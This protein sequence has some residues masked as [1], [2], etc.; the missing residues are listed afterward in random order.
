VAARGWPFLVDAAP[1]ALRQD[2]VVPVVLQF[3]LAAP[4]DRALVFT[5]KQEPRLIR[6]ATRQSPERA[7]PIE[8]CG[9]MPTLS[10]CFAHQP[11]AR[12]SGNAQG[13]IVLGPEPEHVDPLL[14]EDEAI[15]VIF[16][17]NRISDGHH[18]PKVHCP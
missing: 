12:G 3:L 2:R 9:I 8:T 14:I 16:V 17:G 18:A 5:A 6:P 7:V 11:H 13:R 10:K 1:L 15:A 4:D